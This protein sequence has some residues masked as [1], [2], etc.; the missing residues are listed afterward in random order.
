ML[1]NEMDQESPE[2]FGCFLRKKLIWGN[3]IF[4]ANFLILQWVW[5][6]LSQITGTII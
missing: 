2:N 3:L 6:A 5:V 4:L 1:Y